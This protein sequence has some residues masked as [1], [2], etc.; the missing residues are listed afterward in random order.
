MP[1]NLVDYPAVVLPRPP[2]RRGARLSNLAPAERGCGG[3]G[4]SMEEMSHTRHHRPDAQS[5]TTAAESPAED[6]S[7]RLR[8]YLVTMSIR[9]VCFVLVIVIDSWVRWVFAAGAVFL[10]FIAV[11]AVNA[12]RPRMAGRV[13]PVTPGPDRTPLLTDREY[14]HVPATWSGPDG[15]DGSRGTGSAD[16]GYPRG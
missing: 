14:V 1:P 10:P 12:V 11:V 16:D 8:Q 6:Q 9:T 4:R 13:R 5:V 3:S 2:P 7:R 15:R